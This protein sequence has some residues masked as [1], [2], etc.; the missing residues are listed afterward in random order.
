MR[1]MAVQR[2]TITVDGYER[3]FQVHVP[4]NVD[5]PTPLVIVLHGGAGTGRG[6][7]L[8]SEFDRVADQHG[9]MVVYPDGLYRHWNDRRGSGRRMRADVDDVK[10]IA[11]L[12]DHLAGRYT[13]DAKR[14]YAAGISNGGFMT[15]RLACELSDRIA[16][17]ATVVA[18]ISPDFAREC[19][20]P[21]PVRLLM[22]NGTDDP[23]MPY[24]GGSVKVFR[25][26][27]GEVIS[28][29]DTVAFWVK[30]NGCKG[31][32][33]EQTLPD[34]V[35]PDGTQVHVITYSGCSEGGEVIFYRI[36]GGG[37][38]WSKRA[39]GQY[40]PERRVGRVCHAIDAAETIWSFFAQGN[41]KQGA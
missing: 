24:K 30:A 16:G 22:M 3:T 14:V 9:F 36:E 39:G 4:A 6:M 11:T 31:T 12:I 5:R 1:Q 26:E 17:F 37:H 19:R 18:N 40:L 33:V 7:R 35:P 8:M 13:I 23:V 41:L 25:R 21:R 2:E 20:P 32:P 27:L 38:T 34:A 10:F 29:P 15:F 28:A